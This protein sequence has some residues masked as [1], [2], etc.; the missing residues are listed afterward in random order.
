M[1]DITILPF[2]LKGTLVTNRRTG[3]EHTLTRVTGKTNRMFAPK[4]GAYYKESLEV[5][6]SAGVKLEYDKDYVCTYYYDELWDLNAK[7]C[8]AIIV[9]T[10]PNV[11]N[12]I[13]INYQA[14]GGPY[15]LS[16]DE[17]KTVLDE[18]DNSPE[19]IGWDD[20]RNKPLQFPPSL[21]FH[22]YWQLYGLESTIE[23]L[24]QLGEAWA[25]GRKGVLADNRYYYL[26]YIDLAQKAL[27]DYT[28]KVMA[29]ITDR[30][31]PH[32]T[33]K[34]KVGLGL[35][36]NWPMANSTEAASKTVNNKYQ[37]IG[38][39][40]DQLETHIFPAFDAH[41]RDLQNPHK[42]LLTHP[43]LDLYST[44]EIQALMNQR[45]A[46]SEIAYDSAAFQGNT[47]AQLYANFRTG[48]PHT[49][50]LANS[51]IPQDRMAPNIPGWNPDDY[52]LTGANE[53]IPYS[54]LMQTYNDTQG[55]VYFIGAQSPSSF[56]WL[57]VGTYAIR[58]V[59]TDYNGG[60]TMP[61]LTIYRR[62]PAGWTLLG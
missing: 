23:N 58:S 18:V 27:D 21:H 35:L 41:V 45:L 6:T 60:R 11:G 8:C 22:E 43:L 61:R 34:N 10:N 50:L 3:E 51:P 1:A 53:Y 39:V 19:N 31:N 44:A 13:R 42:V 16:I 32:L 33:D 28:V 29:H 47:L 40:Y 59:W 7:E 56:T 26:S 24:D 2:D 37:P 36:N 12:N 62:D 5:R 57:S 17:L 20:I 14:V 15:A 4:F 54:R 38:G 49:S 46:R 55:S 30:Q 25:V 48:L 9:V 52:V